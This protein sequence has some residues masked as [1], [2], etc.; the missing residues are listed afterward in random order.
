MR[1]LAKPPKKSAEP[2]AAAA[3]SAKLTVSIA[4]PNPKN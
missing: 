3:T 2:Y 1:R 4:G